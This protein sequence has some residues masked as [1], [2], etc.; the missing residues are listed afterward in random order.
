MGFVQ[1][2]EQLELEMADDSAIAVDFPM[3]SVG[4]ALGSLDAVGPST[5]GTRSGSL[6]NGTG[7]E[8]TAEG[9]SPPVSGVAYSAA[10]PTTGPESSIR[11]S[12]LRSLS[13]HQ[14]QGNARRESEA[15]TESLQYSVTHEDIVGKGNAS[16]GGDDD[17]AWSPQPES[18]V[19]GS[20]SGVL[21]QRMGQFR[22][23]AYIGSY[24][25]DLRHV[26]ERIRA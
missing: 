12:Q 18:T 1:R 17:R 20:L 3:H 21:V 11:G 22:C 16:R 9:M 8:R 4:I 23:E 2:F 10:P 19:S 6:K 14:G 24:V 5:W 15:E 26:H 13:G 25:H 7:S